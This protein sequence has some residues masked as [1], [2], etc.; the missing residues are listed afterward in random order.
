MKKNAV[1]V[2][3]VRRA[4]VSGGVIAAR[5]RPR[6]NV[7]SAKSAKATKLRLAAVTGDVGPGGAE[8]TKGAQGRKA[9]NPRPTKAPSGR[10]RKQVR[11]TRGTEPKGAR[12]PNPNRPMSSLDAAAKVL[13]DAGEPMR[14]KDIVEAAAKRGL[15]ES[16]NGKTPA[17]TVYASII[18]EIRD[19]G[20]DSRFVKKDR[21]LFA[22]A[23]KGA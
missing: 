16:K 4:K 12:K 15:W 17:A 14:V 7:G 19:K 23:G 11:P 21:G 1:R 22:A 8:G 5:R 3:H 2:G 13:T 20:A 18:R 10:K 9:A 6:A